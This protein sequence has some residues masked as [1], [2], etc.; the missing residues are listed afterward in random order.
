MWQHTFAS[1][2]ANCAKTSLAIGAGKSSLMRIL[3]GQDEEYE[4]KLQLS[5]GIKIGYLQQEPEL[6]MS[7]TVLENIQP[8][9]N[10]TRAM[11]KEFEEASTLFMH[12][13]MQH[14]SPQNNMPVQLTKQ[15]PHLSMYSSQTQATT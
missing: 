2:V 7:S 1:L 3:A 13:Q 11:L 5:P 15:H 9:F 6:D 10:D 4:G 14:T 8:A 12:A